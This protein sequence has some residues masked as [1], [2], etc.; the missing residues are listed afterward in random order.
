MTPLANL[1]LAECDFGDERLTKR[2]IKID[3]AL[4]LK[5]GQPLSQVFPNASDLKRTYEFFTNSKTSFQTVI[6]PE[7]K[8]TAELIR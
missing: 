2:A 4:S 8:T 3:E 1:C 6:S 5:Y 7:H